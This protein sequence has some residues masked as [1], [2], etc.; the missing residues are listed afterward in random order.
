M[1]GCGKLELGRRQFLRN[2]LG[3]VGGAAAAA[4]PVPAAAGGRSG[5]P[6]QVLANL[7]DLAVNVPRDI[8][9]PDTGSP[10]VVVKL[11]AA[12]PGGVGPDGDIV[13][14]STLCP[15]KGYPLAYAAS[16]KTLNC[17]GHFSRFDAE[18]EGQQVWGH[19]TQNLAM[20]RL[21]L[22]PN[23]DIAAVGVDEL[24][25]GRIGNVLES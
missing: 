19:A 9:Y 11:G 17:P 5:Y 2:G 23:G 6:A 22:R 20:F 18:K 12:V 24:I 8:H 7:R 25:Y 1:K 16:D 10:G 15:H 4:V 21:A 3:A 13:A 14:Y